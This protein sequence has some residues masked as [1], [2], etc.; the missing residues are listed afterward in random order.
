[1]PCRLNEF[2]VANRL[3]S[4]HPTAHDEGQQ[5]RDAHSP[6]IEKQSAQD[7]RCHDQGKIIVISASG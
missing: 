5:R 2:L 4:V 3:V 7:V 6:R 1:M